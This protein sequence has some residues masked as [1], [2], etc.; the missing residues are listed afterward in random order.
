MQVDDTIREQAA[1]WAAATGDP[2]FEDWD[3]FTLWLEQDPRHA[4]AYDRTVA[5]VDE[6]VAILAAATPA[7]DAEPAAPA[8]PRFFEEGMTAFPPPTTSRRGFPSLG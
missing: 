3:A 7:N 1:S 8:A 6:G 4:E 2:A 5:A